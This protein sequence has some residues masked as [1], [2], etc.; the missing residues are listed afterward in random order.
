MA[1][2]L[3]LGLLNGVDSLDLISELVRM[4]K[5]EMYKGMHIYK[6]TYIDSDCFHS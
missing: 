2:K 3:Q 4:S 1:A 6:V 5:S